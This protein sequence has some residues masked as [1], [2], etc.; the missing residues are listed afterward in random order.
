MAAAL[1]MGAAGCA[2]GPSAA[3]EAQ[4]LEA[5]QRDGAALSQ[6][7]DELEDR[8]LADQ[9]NLLLWQELARRHQQVSVVV[10]RTQ[11]EH[12]SSMVELLEHQEEK[13]R[14]L[15]RRHV[16]ELEMDL[17]ERPALSRASAPGAS[18]ARN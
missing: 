16:A 6:A 3:E 15:K 8:M 18:R 4:R 14:K 7:A 2:G 13:A 1:G 11:M 17:D 9:A 5:I 12:F 10:T